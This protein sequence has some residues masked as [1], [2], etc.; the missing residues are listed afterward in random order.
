MAVPHFS[1]KSGSRQKGIC[2]AAHFTYIIREGSYKRSDIEYVKHSNYPEW[3]AE[4]PV[5]FWKAADLY[6]RANG[7]MY[8][9]LEIALPRELNKS[10]RIELLE[11]F[12]DVQLGNNHPYTAVIH[13]PYALDG[14]PNPHAHVML[15][16]R[17]LD[18]VE[19]PETSFFSR[20]NPKHPEVG[21]ASKDR[22]WSDRGKIQELRSI[23]E[24]TTNESLEKAGRRERV[25]LRSLRAQGVNRT[26]EPK[27]GPSQTAM[28]RKGI[29]TG[30]A[31]DVLQMRLI[32]SQEKER[33]ETR[34]ELT[35]AKIDLYSTRKK[36][37]TVGVSS[38]TILQLVKKT[39]LDVYSQLDTLEK[40]QYQLGG[41]KCRMSQEIRF[42][43]SNDPFILKRRESV[44]SRY[45]K[46]ND[47]LRDLKKYE[48]E[49]ILVGDIT[50]DIKQNDNWSKREAL[51][52]KEGF[53]NQVSQAQGHQFEQSFEQ[54]KGLSLGFSKQYK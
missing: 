31:Q 41:Y 25:D 54:E 17:R 53:Q 12:L 34:K 47:E 11:K 50:L 19:R 39:K 40:T 9:E 45:E 32:A 14:K 43:D 26:S 4:N 10:Q 23:W 7:R 18:G 44:V 13:K 3:A 35:K 27:L 22:A 46:M 28:L 15:S 16:E 5:K 6:E 49:L 42:H 37:T 20:A 51:V 8:T 48:K 52:D 21:G 24:K 1:V 29:V 30:A 36:E 33:K 2:A 38:Q